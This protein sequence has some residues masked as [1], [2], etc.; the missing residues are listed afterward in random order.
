M[1]NFYLTER[2]AESMTIAIIGQVN[3]KI[4]MAGVKQ[5]NSSEK[6]V[7]EG[8]KVVNKFNCIGCHQIDGYRGDILAKYDEDLNEG[9]PRLNGEGHRVQLDWFHYF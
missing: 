3:D 9:P 1:P 5:L 6:I 4:P 8:M 2:E 7:A